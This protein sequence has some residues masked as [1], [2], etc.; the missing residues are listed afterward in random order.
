M[1][2][3][4]TISNEN[5]ISN[6]STRSS[7]STKLPPALLRQ[8]DQAIVDRDPPPHVGEAA[9]ALGPLGR[10]PGRV[11]LGRR[12]LAQNRR[13]TSMKCSWLAARSGS[14]VLDHFATNR[15]GVILSD[16]A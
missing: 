9:L 14:S 13:H 11:V 12:G 8:V 15:A 16:M 7:L 2:D 5:T 6:G 10:G 1:S 4:E 3:T